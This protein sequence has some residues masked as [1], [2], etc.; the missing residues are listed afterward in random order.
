MAYTRVHCKEAPLYHVCVV[1]RELT[2][3]DACLLRLCKTARVLYLTVSALASANVR[4][5]PHVHT[6]NE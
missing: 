3:S 5:R 2:M 6:H 1:G 4:A